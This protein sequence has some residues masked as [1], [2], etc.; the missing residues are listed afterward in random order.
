MRFPRIFNSSFISESPRR[1]QITPRL[2]HNHGVFRAPN[3]HLSKPELRLGASL[4][5]FSVYLRKAFGKDR[6]SF[7]K[8]RKLK[9]FS[10]KRCAFNYW[11][12]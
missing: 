9:K 3:M 11:R 10:E 4:F 1:S 8:L 7:C 6:K 5:S 2:A 12:S